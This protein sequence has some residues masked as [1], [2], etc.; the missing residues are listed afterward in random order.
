MLEFSHFEGEYI[1][2][3]LRSA[4]HSAIKRVCCYTDPTGVAR[5]FE[6]A[7]SEWRGWSG[8]KRWE[9]IEGELTLELTSD[10]AGHITLDVSIVNDL[11]GP[12][13]WRVKSQ[14]SLEAGQLDGLA[15]E[16]ARLFRSTRA[17]N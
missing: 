1:Q 16:A 11:G 2:V 12:D 7:A 14:L 13:T 6:A 8:A 5:L 9:S 15:K 3:D 4:S 10:R 17:G